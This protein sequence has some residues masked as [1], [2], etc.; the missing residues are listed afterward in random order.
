MSEEAQTFNFGTREDR[1]MSAVH[2]DL[3]GSM[4]K[5]GSDRICGSINQQLERGISRYVFDLTDL[6]HVHPEFYIHLLML[7][8]KVN[9]AR[10]KIMIFG[11]RNDTLRPLL[12]VAGNVG[13][14]EHL[15][16][17]PNELVARRILTQLRDDVERSGTT[18]VK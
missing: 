13:F 18:E 2:F 3:R 7:G 15:E 9:Q 8:A 11:F 12:V 16:I 17:V 6:K 4:S 10:G 14:L 5:P 1:A